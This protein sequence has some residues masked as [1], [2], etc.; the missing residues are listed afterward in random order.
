MSNLRRHWIDTARAVRWMIPQKSGFVWFG[1]VCFERSTRFA[2]SGCSQNRQ[3][4]TGRNG[5]NPPREA[6][7]VAKLIV[8]DLV[9][10]APPTPFTR[11][12]E[13]RARVLL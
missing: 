1:V 6:Y 3:P 7:R 13:K 5:H 11:L 4:G 8:L 2:L 12:I 9:P 10:L